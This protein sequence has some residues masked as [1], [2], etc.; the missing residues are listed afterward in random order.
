MKKVLLSFAFLL[1]TYVLLAQKDSLQLDENDKY[2]YYKVSDTQILADTVYQ[3]AWQFAK[4]LADAGKPTAGN[5]DKA[6]HVSSKFLVYSGTSLIRKESGQIKYTLNFQA[7]DGKYRYK[8]SSFIFTPYVRDRFG[9]MV[10]V[11]GIEVPLENMGVKYG[12]KNLNA[13]LDQVAE[14]ALNLSAR[15]KQAVDRKKDTVAPVK[16]KKVNTGN[17]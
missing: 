2:V 12:Q 7:A 8:I 4:G 16:I 5:A 14:Y 9:N 15:L 6:F 1:N 10:P 17:W 13:C 11:A 3:R